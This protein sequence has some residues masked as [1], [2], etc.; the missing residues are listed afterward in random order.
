MCF[1]SKEREDK[2]RERKRKRE[3]ESLP[4]SSSREEERYLRKGDLPSTI[5]SSVPSHARWA[6]SGAR[7]APDSPPTTPY[8]VS[9]AMSRPVD[10]WPGWSSVPPLDPGRSSR[11]P[12]SRVE[13]DA[14]SAASTHVASPARLVASVLPAS[15]ATLKEVGLPLLFIDDAVIRFSCLKR[16][17]GKFSSW[18]LCRW[19][20]AAARTRAVR[21]I[22][23]WDSLSTEFANLFGE[24][25]AVKAEMEELQARVALLSA[26]RDTSLEALHQRSY[27]LEQLDSD[28]ATVTSLV[29]STTQ[30]ISHLQK[31]K[32]ALLRL[33]EEV[34]EMIED[35]LDRF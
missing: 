16:A 23:E 35:S 30:E 29:N 15:K 22:S 1:P 2:E 6:R 14:T 19:P 8:L 21:L 10:G 18:A 4:I 27:E 26:L 20:R 3:R 28:S 9:I 34:K 25:E 32:Q 33:T 17:C 24:L 31:E 11:S 5:V 7:S 12:A 13:V